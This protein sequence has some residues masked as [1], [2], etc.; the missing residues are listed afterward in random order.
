[1]DPLGYDMTQIMHKFQRESLLKYRTFAVRRNMLPFLHPPPVASLSNE[2]L[3]VVFLLPPIF[4][5]HAG[6]SKWSL[7]SSETFQVEHSYSHQVTWGEKNTPKNNKKHITTIV[8]WGFFVGYRTWLMLF[9][10]IYR[11]RLAIRAAFSGIACHVVNQ[12]LWCGKV[13]FCWST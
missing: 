6:S 3:W 1:M 5:Q 11:K 12:Q 13:S 8:F 9:T 10:F 4:S 7:E 2:Y